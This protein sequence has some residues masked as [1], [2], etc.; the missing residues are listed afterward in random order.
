MNIRWIK[1]GIRDFFM[2]TGISFAFIFCAIFFIKFLSTIGIGA[3]YASTIMSLCLV[4]V[5]SLLFAYL[6][7]KNS[8][9]ECEKL[10]ALIDVSETKNEKNINE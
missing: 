1:K 10:K 4:F 8:I 5:G 6:D 9:L 3:E 7:H 2:V